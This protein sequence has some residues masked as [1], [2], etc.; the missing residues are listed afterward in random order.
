MATDHVPKL[1]QST[2]PEL[3]ANDLQVNSG[4]GV[5]SCC[6]VLTKGGY[7]KMCSKKMRLKHRFMEQT[8]T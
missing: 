5:T 2:N 7:F 1:S 6:Q 4:T 8:F 3:L